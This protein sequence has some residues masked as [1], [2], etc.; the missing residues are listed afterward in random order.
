MKELEMKPML[1]RPGREANASISMLPE[2]PRF[3]RRML[4]TNPWAQTIP[5]H[6]E[7][8]AQ[9]SVPGF[10][11]ES[12]EEELAKDCLS[13]KRAT[14]SEAESAAGRICRKTQRIMDDPRR[15]V[16]AIWGNGIEELKF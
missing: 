9:G 4:E 5:N 15:W 11:D 8:A 13:F 1:L 10:H 12:R 6:F 14:D 3:L 7:S 16:M 2:S